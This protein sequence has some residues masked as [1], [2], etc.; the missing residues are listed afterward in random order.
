MTSISFLILTYN[1][2]ALVQRCFESLARTL[3]RNDVVE[4]LVLDNASSDDTPGYLREF[5]RDRPKVSCLW[6]ARNRGVAGGRDYLLRRAHGDVLVLLDSDT[7][8]TGAEFPGNLVDALRRPGVGVVGV[9]AHFV[10]AG[11]KW[12]FTVAAGDYEGP[13]DLVPG[14]CQAFRRGLADSCRMDL[15]FNPYWLEDTDFCFQAASRGYTIW[16]LPRVACGVRHE[17]GKS[18]PSHS[19]FAWKYKYFVEK[20]RGKR[21]VAFEQKETNRCPNGCT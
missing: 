21:V 16:S 9:G 3:Q 19:D 17:W 1:R 12:P 2:C 4:W 14:F 5:M 11:W 10:P 13:C 8:I 15:A 18:G 20:W 6:S 7:E